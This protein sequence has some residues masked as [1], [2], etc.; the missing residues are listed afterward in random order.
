MGVAV[1]RFRYEVSPETEFYF[2]NV[3]HIL[4]FYQALLYSVL[5]RRFVRSKPPSVAD[6]VGQGDR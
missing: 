2:T 5:A 6:E 1:S 3:Y 4:P